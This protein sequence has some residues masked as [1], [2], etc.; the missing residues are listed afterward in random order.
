[1]PN[2]RHSHR[3]GN[4][5][6]FLCA[7][8]VTATEP[9]Q[10]GT[11][12]TQP[13]SFSSQR[14]SRALSVRQPGY[15][16][17]DTSCGPAVTQPPSFS[18]QRESRALSVRRHGYGNPDTSCGP[19]SAQPP[20]FPS[21]RESR[22]LS[23]SQHGY[24]NPD[25]SCG[26]AVTQPPSFSP[27]QESGALSLIQPDVGPQEWSKWY[28]D[29][30][31]GGVLVGITVSAQNQGSGFPLRRERRGWGCAPILTFPGRGKEDISDTLAAVCNA[32]ALSIR[33]YPMTGL[34]A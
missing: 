34:S 12:S 26:P 16:N 27:Q 20:P 23:M 29:L 3:S 10:G 30:C 9:R 13:P 28:V 11:A 22:T 24:R 4:P 2:P 25:T 15:G 32:I 5:E 14:E 18:S 21:Q 33:N 8:A 19:A 7:T 17:P 31:T 1:M 6:P